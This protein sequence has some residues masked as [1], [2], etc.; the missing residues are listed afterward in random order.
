MIQNTIKL[1][2]LIPVWTTLMFSQGNSVTGKLELVE[3]F[4]CKVA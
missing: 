4:C 2:R 3:S 1:D